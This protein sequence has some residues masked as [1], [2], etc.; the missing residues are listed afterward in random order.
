MIINQFAWHTLRIVHSWNTLF[1][2]P[3]Y[4]H[5]SIGKY[6]LRFFPKEFFACVRH[7]SHQGWKFTRWARR[8]ADLWNNLGFSLCIALPVCHIVA[9]SDDKEKSK[10]GVSADLVCRCWTLVIEFNKSLFSSIIRLV[11]YSITTSLIYELLL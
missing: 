10:M 11:N 2:Q 6:R 3:W 7:G 1:F 9:T 8:Y 4:N 5:T